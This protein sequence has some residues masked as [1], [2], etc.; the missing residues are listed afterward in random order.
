MFKKSKNEKNKLKKLLSLVLRALLSQYPFIHKLDKLCV[1]IKT[2]EAY[3]SLDNERVQILTTDL[4]RKCKK[5]LVSEESFRL[6]WKIVEENEKYG[7]A[8]S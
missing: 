7:S 3:I 6:L 1:C 5:F 4:G 2:R 8:I